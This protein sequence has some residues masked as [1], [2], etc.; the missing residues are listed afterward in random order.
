M[1]RHDGK[2]PFDATTY[3]SPAT[4]NSM[5]ALRVFCDTFFD[6]HI[7]DH[8]EP[9]HETSLTNFVTLITSSDAFFAR[10]RAVIPEL[11]PL[12]SPNETTHSN[13][14]IQRVLQLTK[15]L[16]RSPSAD[17]SEL[18]EDL[19]WSRLAKL[20]WQQRAHQTGHIVKDS[21]EQ[22]SRPSSPLIPSKVLLSLE[23]HSLLADSPRSQAEYSSHRQ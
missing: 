3:N 2:D 6:Q 10:A 19:V 9:I 22:K 7:R 11:Q 12:A 14:N 23:L 5:V 20:S 21:K 18:V 4:L 15:D 8:V 17:L 13:P 1:D 16:R